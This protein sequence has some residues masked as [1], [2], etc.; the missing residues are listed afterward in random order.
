MRVGE[1]GAAHWVCG[2]FEPAFGAICAALPLPRKHARRFDT[3]R[4]DSLALTSPWVSLLAQVEV[5]SPRARYPLRTGKG[6]VH[7]V[8]RFCTT[9]YGPEIREPHRRGELWALG[10]SCL[11]F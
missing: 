1:L 2:A 8:R 4:H 7:P 5:E 10:P 6:V 3:L 9:L 11:D